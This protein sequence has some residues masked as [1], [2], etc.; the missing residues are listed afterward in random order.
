[1]TENIHSGHRQRMRQR[2][3]E[4]GAETLN[5]HELLEVLLYHCIPRK[6]TNEL[7]HKLI[8][9]YGSLYEVLMADW[10]DL[11]DKGEVSENTAVFFNLLLETTKRISKG[12]WK[13]GAKLESSSDSAEFCV[14][15]LGFERVEVFYV[16]CLDAGFRVIKACELNRGS[17][18]SVNIDARAVTEKAMRYKA[19]HVILLHNHPGGDTEPSIEDIK[20]TKKVMEALNTIEVNVLDHII[21]SGDE[22]FSFADN[23]VFDFIENGGV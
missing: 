17:A 19:A 16:L 2:I 18:L 22:H 1:M 11:V 3:M 10:A 4:H 5:D 8:N 20:L 13:K 15:L 21:V 23:G 6:D 9:E 12:R 7:G 14:D